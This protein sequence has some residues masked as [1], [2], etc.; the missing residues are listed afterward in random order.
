MRV[1][2]YY[3]EGRYRDNIFITRLPYYKDRFK[4]LFS[5]IKR[6]SPKIILDAG[7]GEGGFA[8]LIKG[9]TKSRVFAVDISK[10]AVILAQKNG[11]EA[12]VA[13]LSKK[14]PFQDNFFDLVLA[15]EIIEHLLDPDG[16]LKEINRVLKQK[17]T[18]I[19]STPNLSS[20]FNRMLF[21]LG[22]YPIFLEASTESSEIGLGI[23]KKMA[24]TTQPVGHL[25]VFNLSA[26]RDLLGLCGFRITRIIGQPVDFKLPNSFLSFFYRIFDHF[27]ARIPFLAADLIIVAKKK[28]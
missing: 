10:K 22:I 23:F 28:E 9:K 19:L 6:V 24:L 12:K 26:L 20:W 2:E 16:F 1:E 8:K 4:L 3:Q 15:N 14:I 5:E 18:L 21:L 17:G 27:F 25:H 13:D 11:L 7:C